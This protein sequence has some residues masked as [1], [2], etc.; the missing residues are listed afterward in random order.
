VTGPARCL[1]AV[2][3]PVKVSAHPAQ[4]FHLAGTTLKLA[5]NTVHGTINGASIP[6]G[7]SRALVGTATFTRTGQP[8]KH[9]SATLTIVACPSP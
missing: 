9:V 2:Q 1:P 4:G 8:A 7:A 5:G 3:A 6:P